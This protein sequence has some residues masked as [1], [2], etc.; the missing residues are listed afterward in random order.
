[1]QTQLLLKYASENRPRFILLS[2]QTVAG[3]GVSPFN[4]RPATLLECT[5]RK[6]SVLLWCSKRDNE[7]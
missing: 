1:M 2:L 6:A 7:A 5:S 3:K 4:P